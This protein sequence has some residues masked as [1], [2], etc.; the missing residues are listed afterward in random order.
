MTWCLVYIITSFFSGR[1]GSLNF[2]RKRNY[3]IFRFPF[4][5][6]ILIP[7]RDRPISLIF[8]N[9]STKGD[10]RMRGFK[11]DALWLLKVIS[12]LIISSSLSL[13]PAAASSSSYYSYFQD[14]IGHLNQPVPVAKYWASHRNTR[15]QK[16][17]YI[18]CVP[19]CSL[20]SFLASKNIKINH[21]QSQMLTAFC[22]MCFQ[23]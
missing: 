3:T 1:N 22:H 10:K 20:F 13:S 23:N 2:I 6:F 4:S 15:K 5:L 12:L 18:H 7:I 9:N 17:S 8:L 16:S 14:N 21:V 19:V 11:I